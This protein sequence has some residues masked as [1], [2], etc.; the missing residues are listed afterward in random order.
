MIRKTWFVTGS[1]NGFG[2]STVRELLKQGYQVAAATRSVDRLVSALSPQFSRN[3]LPLQVD[4][5]NESSIKSSIKHTI[6]YFGQLDVVVNNAGYGLVGAVEEVSH[7]EAVQ[8]FEINFLAV[9]S[10]VQTV[11]PHFRSR[12][13]GY[14][15]NISSLAAVT[16]MPGFAFYAASKAALTALTDVLIDEVGPLGI[17]ATSVLPGPFK[18]NFQESMK[19]STHQIEAYPKIRQLKPALITAPLPGS[20]DLAAKLFIELAHNPNPPRLIFLGKRAVERGAL[21]NRS[22]LKEIEQW[23][24]LGAST[25]LR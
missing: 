3:F 13:N 20:A 22:I 14:F 17:R 10:I 9:H 24:E 21:K 16:A 4:L 5:T 6:D 19:D 15:L 18:T 23:K 1:S 25:D 11:L 7:S 2:L 12:R 8:Q